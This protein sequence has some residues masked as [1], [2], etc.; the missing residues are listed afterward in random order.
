MAK[1]ILHRIGEHE[2]IT[3]EP[4]R[5]ES[6]QPSG[7]PQESPQMRPRAHTY[8]GRLKPSHSRVKSD[9]TDIMQYMRMEEGRRESDE[10]PQS[11]HTQATTEESSFHSGMGMKQDDLR[12]SDGTP[13]EMEQER[14]FE[15]PTI[16]VEVNI[17]INVDSGVIVLRSEERFVHGCKNSHVCQ[18]FRV[19]IA[20][21]VYAGME[22]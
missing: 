20:G 11:P 9:I 22:S 5:P 19:I 15:I 17:T 2:A 8:S 7:S 12:Q 10:L 16:D 3:E 6:A 4:I 14:E 21:C 13:V 18:C 1:V